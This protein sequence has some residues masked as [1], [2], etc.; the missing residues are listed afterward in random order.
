MT[1]RL[2]ESVRPRTGLLQVAGDLECE[3]GISDVGGL[4]VGHSE[5]RRT[6]IPAWN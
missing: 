2:Q 1:L 5:G 4:K 3:V 6:Q